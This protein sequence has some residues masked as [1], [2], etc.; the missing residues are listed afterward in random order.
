MPLNSPGAIRLSGGQA[1]T[2][3]TVPFKVSPIGQ[4]GQLGQT[5]Q[6]RPWRAVGQ[7]VAIVGGIAPCSQM[8][9]SSFY[10]VHSRQSKC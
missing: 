4:L 3:T 2:R 10:N 8:T 6:G 1:L 5:C 7:S 9:G